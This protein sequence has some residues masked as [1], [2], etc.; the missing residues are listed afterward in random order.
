[1]KIGFHA[2]LEQFSPQ[3][4]LKLVQQAQKAVFQA[5]LS[6]DHFHPWSNKQGESGFAWSWLGAAMQATKLEF[7]IVNAPGQR[8]HPAIIA[9]AVATLDNMFPK[10]FWMSVGSGQAINENITGERWPSKEER[11]IRLKESVEVMWKLWE[12]EYITHKG[13][14]HVENAKL[15]TKPTQTPTVI[16]AAL[17]EKTAKW[18]SEW[19]DGMITISKPLEELKKMVT[20]FRENGTEK[21]MVLKVQVSYADTEEK[22][23][24]GAWHQWKNN[25]FPSK[26]ISNLDTP[27]QFDTIGEK[28]R[29]EDLREHVIISHQAEPFIDKIKTY[30]DMGFEK[31][32]IHNV[33]EEQEA[34]IKFFGKEIIPAFKEQEVSL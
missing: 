7:G 3:H 21:P 8:Y 28:V 34:F 30:S 27:A 18:L 13:K 9:Q 20:A 25:I 1:M 23:L 16:G 32:I 14:V 24:E 11:N 33:N 17:T 12:G 26:L 6:S 5:I 10:R 2:S 31:I 4:L 19:A 29:K 22:A 15:F